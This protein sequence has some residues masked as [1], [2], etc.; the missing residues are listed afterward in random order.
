MLACKSSKANLEKCTRLF[1]LMGLVVALVIVEFAIEFKSKPQTSM[2]AVYNNSNRLDED[3]FIPDTKVEQEIPKQ[4]IPVPPQP[5]L[6]DIKIV[7]D[8]KN[9]VETVLSSTETDEKDAVVI[10]KIDYSNL[11]EQKVEEDVVEDIPFFVIEEVPKFPGC[12]GNNEQLKQCMQEKIQAF[13][14]QNFNAEIAQD[15]G[16]EPGTKRIFV[17]FVIDKNGNIANIESRAP[18]KSLQ[19]EA[20]RV[21]KSLPKMEP[22]RQRGKPVRVKYSLPIVF[23]VME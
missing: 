4:N 15:L 23:Q 12:Q 17:T 7:S 18:H 3:E 11:K 20:E 14:S 13:V 8:N 6:E 5:I 19:M 10:Q 21:V 16:L 1:L 2:E 9:I 22:G